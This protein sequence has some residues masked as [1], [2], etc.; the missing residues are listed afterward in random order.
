[1]FLDT[2]GLLNLL[3]DREP[4]HTLARDLFVAAQTY[5]VHDYV[6]AEL[7]ALADVRGVPRKKSLDFVRDLVGDA[8]V[9][10]IFVDGPLCTRGL[11]LLCQRLDKRYS[12]CDAVSFL[13]MRQHGETEALTNDA[14]FE[15]EGFQRLLTT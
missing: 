10:T 2:S 5:I 12:L 7:I 15:Q 11:G 9:T 8:K 4:A 13:L 3:Y 1:M 14:H 6:L